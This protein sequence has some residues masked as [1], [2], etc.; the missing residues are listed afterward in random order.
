MINPVLPAYHVR[1]L[2]ID[3]IIYLMYNKYAIVTAIV[4]YDHQED[5]YH[6]EEH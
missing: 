6:G 1:K 4:T 3:I 5:G 2:Y